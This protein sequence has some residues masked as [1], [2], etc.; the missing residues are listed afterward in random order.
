MTAKKNPIKTE[1]V[2]EYAKLP[3]VKLEEKLDELRRAKPTDETRKVM[4]LVRVALRQR[5]KA[6]KGKAIFFEE[7]NDHHLLLFASTEG[8]W[9]MAGNSVLFYSLKVA[10]R[11]GRRCK[12]V[13]DKDKYSV[14]E[15]GI[16]SFR[17]VDRLAEQL[18]ELDIVPDTE[19]STPELQYFKLPRI[20]T[21]EQIAKMR[22]YSKQDLE[23]IQ[24]IIMP[25]A[26]MP[27]LY[28]AIIEMNRL[29]YFNT[30]N[31]SDRFVRDVIGAPL[32]A[33]ADAVLRAY[34]N[35]ANI[36]VQTT[37]AR[38]EVQG[39]MAKSESRQLAHVEK[40]TGQNLMNLWMAVVDL[41]NRMA[42]V[43]NLKIMHHKQIGEILARLVEIERVVEREYSKLLRPLINAEK[44]EKE[45][46]DQ[47]Q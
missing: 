1:E 11:I 5:Q 8:F 36:R 25:Q 24:E 31:M 2:D 20:Y 15:D 37:W 41:K 9:K 16:I 43:E 44:A 22:D 29:I 26:P 19:L 30:K 6:I 35:Y 47:K 10:E 40:A 3:L 39:L 45:T 42:N 18:A 12:V 32:L 34:L 7:T 28:R 38:H 46:K 13:P 23:R 14:S 33:Q 21:D 27:N 4:R 17:M